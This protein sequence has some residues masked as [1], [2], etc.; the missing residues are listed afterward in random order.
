MMML[1]F[2]L[3]SRLLKE[4]EMAWICSG[5]MRVYRAQHCRIEELGRRNGII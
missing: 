3:R 2:R 1:M 4:A 5:G